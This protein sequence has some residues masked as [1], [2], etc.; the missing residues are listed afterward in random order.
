MILRIMNGL[1]VESLRIE[2][3]LDLLEESKERRISKSGREHGHTNLVQAITP[4][5]IVIDS[6]RMTISGLVN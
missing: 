4:L 1:R 5:K 3:R 6:V 2:K